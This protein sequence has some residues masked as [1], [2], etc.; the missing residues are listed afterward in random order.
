MNEVV[1]GAPME[2]TQE[3]ISHFKVDVVV[4]GEFEIDE[5]FPDIYKTPKALGIYKDIFDRDAL[6]TVDI[7][8]RIIANR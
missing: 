5:H 6:T 3:L 2:V 4:H 1:I 7:V 8:D